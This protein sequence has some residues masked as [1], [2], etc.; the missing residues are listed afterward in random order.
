MQ[1]ASKPA[2][3][4]ETGSVVGRSDFQPGWFE[5][6]AVA[7][8]SP[9]DPPRPPFECEGE[10]TF[11]YRGDLVY[12]H[13]TDPR[14]E[15]T[16]DNVPR[17]RRLTAEDLRRL[18]AEMPFPYLAWSTQRTDE[19]LPESRYFGLGDAVSWTLGKL[20]FSECDACRNRKAWLNRV[21]LWPRRR[22]N[23]G[24]SPG[25]ENRGRKVM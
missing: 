17:S 4:E 11:I 12:A 5:L 18:D 1:I 9:D 16:A 8:D 7:G 14:D 3:A 21:P 25:E 19:P 15:R 10:A 22:Q 20:G 24:P 6:P 23:P 2:T 13:F